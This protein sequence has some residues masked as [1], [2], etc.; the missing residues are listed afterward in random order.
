LPLRPA[1]LPVVAEVLPVVAEVLPVVAD[2][3]PVVA[4]VLPDVDLPPV[5]ALL[6]APLSAV[7]VEPPHAVNKSKA[8]ADR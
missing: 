2:V 5:G 4:D 6:S 8:K 1:P 3:L 7:T